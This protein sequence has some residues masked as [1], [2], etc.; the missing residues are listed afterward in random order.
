M[1][2]PHSLLSPAFLFRFA[3]PCWQRQPVWGKELAPL[4]ERYAIRSFSEWEGRPPFADFRLAWS[5]EG[6]AFS[7]KVTGKKQPPWCRDSK[8]DDSDGLQLWFDTRNTQNIHRAG[9]YCHRFAFLPS[10]T[11][12]RQDQ[13]LAA[14]LAINRARESPREIDRKALQVRSLVQHDGYLLLGYIP[15]NTLTG[16]NPADHPALGFTY[17]VADRELGLQTFT[18]GT[19]FPFDEDPSVWGTLELA[20]ENN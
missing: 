12:P 8:I 10:G 19:E 20:K 16:F 7:L 4:P 17:C 5:E 18:V 6:L 1:S 15:A 14:L 3:L 13:P 2:N 11:G 9:R